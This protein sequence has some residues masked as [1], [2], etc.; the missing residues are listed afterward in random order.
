MVFRTPGA[1]VQ[2]EMTSVPAVALAGQATGVHPPVNQGE[3]VVAVM[4]PE[5]PGTHVH[6]VT[7]DVP[8]E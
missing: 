2:P 5:A 8:I 6:P 3:E 1:Q 7:R 4:A